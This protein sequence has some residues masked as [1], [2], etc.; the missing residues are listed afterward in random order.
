MKN[1]QIISTLHINNGGVQAK[2]GNGRY[3]LIHLQQGDLDGACA[4]YST[5]MILILIGAVRYKD[6]S[7]SGF[8]NDK[9]TAL[10][11]LKKELF[12][13][14]GMHRDGNYLEHEELDSIAKI[15]KRS[16]SK[17]VSVRWFDF[18]IVNIIETI[19]EHLEDDQA[20]L[21]SLS[22]KGA[23]V[24]ALVAIGFEMNKRNEVQKIFC[25]DPSY[26]SPKFGYW[27][28][29]ISLNE[30]S[31]QFPHLQI[32]EDGIDYSVQLQDILIINKKS[33]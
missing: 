9:R 19:Q 3:Q 21:I 2:T 15:L 13:T 10:G 26:P 28:S 17:I 27:N 24:H 12:E 4:V 23:G 11:K 20:V 8:Q 29:Y 18:K 1:I 16:F 32:C 25:L 31:G 7:L 5:I 14:Q 30:N 6:V 22:Y 33:K